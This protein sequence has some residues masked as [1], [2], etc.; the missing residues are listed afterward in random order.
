[1]NDAMHEILLVGSLACVG[2]ATLIMGWF[3]WRRPALDGQTKLTLFFGI[4]VL[5][6]T[7]A[8]ATN[9]VGFQTTQ[10]REFCGSCHVMEPYTEDS[11]N[12]D[13]TSLPSRHARNELFG[14]HNCYGCHADY[15]LAGMVVTKLNG[16]KHVWVYYTK[17]HLWP[18]EAGDRIHLYK[19]FD[20]KNCTHCH[21][22]AT[23]YFNGVR[24]HV[25]AQEDLRSGKTSCASG[26]CHGPAHPFSKRK[27]MPDE[28]TP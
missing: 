24:D 2:I 1:M 16:M 7:S 23:P 12:V 14:E 21:S 9:L 8:M 4:A 18:R 17:A 19:P 3:L 11:S 5:P 25:G 13:S 26:G 28:E 6:I 15:G 22:M 27:L 20:N 10:T